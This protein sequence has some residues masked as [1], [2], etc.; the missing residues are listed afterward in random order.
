MRWKVNKEFKGKDGEMSG[1]ET[2]IKELQKFQELLG[3]ISKF[4]IRGIPKIVF[5][6]HRCLY[7]I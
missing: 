6:A 1:E 7:C 5:R 2:I 4:V 3:D